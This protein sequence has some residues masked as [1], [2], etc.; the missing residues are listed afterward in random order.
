M[1]AGSY[2]AL[3]AR[4][5]SPPKSACEWSLEG[6]EEGS[7]WAAGVADAEKHEWERGQLSMFQQES[8]VSRLGL[9]WHAA[10]NPCY[11]WP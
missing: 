2:A 8:D 3:T 10:V 4:S 11:P 7:C 1:A 9:A 6:E 5:R